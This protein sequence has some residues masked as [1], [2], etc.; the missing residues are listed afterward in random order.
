MARSLRVNPEDGRHHIGHHGA[1][2][3]DV[4]LDDSDRRRF[5]GCVLDAC[6]KF[7]SRLISYC[8]MSNHY[9]LVLHC[10]TG[11]LSSVVQHYA[12]RYVQRFNFDHGFSGALF[13]DRFDSVLITDEA[14]LV[15]A[16]RYDLRNPVEIGFDAIKYPWS[17]AASYVGKTSLPD[18]LDASLALDIVGGSEAFGL[19]LAT[20]VESDKAPWA[21]GTNVFPEQPR[22]GAIAR[23]RVIETVVL[24]ELTKHSLPG[25]QA[26]ARRGTIARWVCAVVAVDS[27]SATTTEIAAQWEF[28]SASAVRAAVSVARRR[29]KTDNELALL[30]AAARAS[31]DA[32]KTARGLTPRSLRRAG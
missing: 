3:L 21:R 32:T 30:L 25:P 6:E 26:D 24:R 20:D 8:L 12:S 18:W 29:A 2:G 19:L 9:H 4:F 5:I 27:G 7:S 28:K 1:R 23:L 22:T 11:E 14:Q 15:A 17:C 10:P 13:D 16:I 31:L